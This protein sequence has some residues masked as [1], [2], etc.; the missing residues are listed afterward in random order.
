MIRFLKTLLAALVLLAAPARADAEGVGINLASAVDWSTGL[1]F[2]DLM[3][4]ARSW[5]GHGDGEWQVMNRD[6]LEAA[7]ALDEHGWPTKIP[8][9]VSS[10]GTLVLTGQP[11]NATGAMGRYLVRW[12][13]AGQIE[14]DLGAANVTHGPNSVEFDYVPG[15][16]LVHIDIIETDPAGVGDYI[17]DITIVR[18]DRAALFDSGEMFNPEWTAL[19]RGFE[20]LRFMDWMHTNDATLAHWQDRPEPDDATWRRYGVPVEV[21]IR[22]AEELGA[23]PWFTIPHLADDDFARNFAALVRDQLDPGLRAWVEFSNEVWNWQFDQAH[24]ADEQAKALWRRNPSWIQVY[25]GRASE[26]ADIWTDVFG[27]EADARL[28]RVIATQTGWMGLEQE[29]LNAPK[30]VAEEKG[31]T[32]PGK[33]FDAYAV[34]GYFGGH[35][36]RGDWADPV[37]DWIADSK[38]VAAAAA[39]SQGLT[40]AARTAYLEAHRFDAAVTRAYEHLAGADGPQEGVHDVP[41][42]VDTAFPYHAGVAADWGLEMVAYEGGTHV[43]A[44]WENHDDEELNDFLIHFNYT[45]EMAA[46]YA[47][48]F[49]GWK[50]VDPGVFVAFNDV[51]APSKYGSWGHL[52]YLGDQNPRWDALVAA[53]DGGAAE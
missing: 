48:L 42:L 18:K 26:V 34:T 44:S 15:T 36:G 31:R 51:E 5:I 32:A 13:G 8:A 4:T 19:I 10:I 24:W 43:V 27:D 9:G 14:V 37:R 39:D 25:A 52:R 30:W 50:A 11:D 12:Q 29:I 49:A 6:D 20:V 2:L 7:G 16:D 21:M 33:H 1:P 40:G 47:Q 38:A 22:L 28:V 41:S 45:P 17:R 35:L 3:K 23:E 46:L 53:R